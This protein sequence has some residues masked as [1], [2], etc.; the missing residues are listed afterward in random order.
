MVL[1]QSL[2]PSFEYWSLQKNPTHTLIEICFWCGEIHSQSSTFCETFHNPKSF[3]SQDSLFP[4]LWTHIFL[5]KITVLINFFGVAVCTQDSFIVNMNV[6]QH[7]TV[8]LTAL[9][10]LHYS[11]IEDKSF[12]PNA[13]KRMGYF[14]QTNLMLVYYI[15]QGSQEEQKQ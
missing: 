14:F 12:E 11:Y 1:L 10:K 3:F 15:S 5:F 4:W 9:H 8:A 13:H 2:L 6:L 7:R